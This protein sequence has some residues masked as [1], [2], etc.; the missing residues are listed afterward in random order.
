MVLN[1]A[2]NEDKDLQ[3]EILSIF[4]HKSSPHIACRL[5]TELLS[6]FFKLNHLI[7]SYEL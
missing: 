4:V 7:D 5:I 6:N 1:L 2:D 3:R